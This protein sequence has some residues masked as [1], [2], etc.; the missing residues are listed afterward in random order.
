Y[1]EYPGSSNFTHAIKTVDL[2]SDKKLEFLLGTGS[3][4]VPAIYWDPIRDILTGIAY[5]ADMDNDGKPE[6]FIDTNADGKADVYYDMQN[7]TKT[8]VIYSDVNG[9]GKQD[10]V[11]DKNGNGKADAGE[12][13]YN[14]AA[15]SVNSIPQE[16]LQSQ[17]AGMLAKYWYIVVLAL[18]V[19]IL[20]GIVVGVR[21]Q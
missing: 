19:L 18:V 1:I 13:Y 6:Y 15:D 11:V 17:L 20:A 4:D 7:N 21:K 14:S 10:L 9:D 5:A 2:N 3:S 16:T 8:P 12:Q